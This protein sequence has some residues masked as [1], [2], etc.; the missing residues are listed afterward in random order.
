MKTVGLKKGLFSSILTVIS[1]LILGYI[2]YAAE[3]ESNLKKPSIT[4]I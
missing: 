3:N 1:I 4:I 2:S